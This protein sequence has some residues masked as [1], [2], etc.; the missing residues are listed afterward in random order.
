MSET[1][2][3]ALGSNMR[4]PGLGGPRVVIEAAFEALDE[5]GL[6]VLATSPIIDS[7]PIGP[8]LR[9]YA[10]AVAVVETSLSPPTLLARL[11]QLE[12]AFGRGRNQ[13]RGARWRA[14]VLDLDIVLWSGGVWAAPDLAIPHVEFRNRDF[15]LEPACK[16]AA[17]WR[18]PLTGLSVAHLAA[19]LAKPKQK[20]A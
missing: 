15:V 10:N 7:A 20:G 9:R 17:P 8:S 16:I 3:I 11:H 5:R 6:D 2:L 18:D 1:Y 13:R 4:V 12:H 19:R 14:R